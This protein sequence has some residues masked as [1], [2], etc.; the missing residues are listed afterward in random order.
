[1]THD[2]SLLGLRDLDRST[3]EAILDRADDWLPRMEQGGAIPAGRAV[4]GLMFL[5]DS[6]RT[7]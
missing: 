4:V 3:I 7:R 6:T 5:E 1:M 2:S